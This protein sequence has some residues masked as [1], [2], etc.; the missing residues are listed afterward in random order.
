MGRRA[1]TGKTARPGSLRT[2]PTGPSCNI[3]LQPAGELEA[4]EE[5]PPVIG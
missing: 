5:A 3:A 1:I 2:D 4:V